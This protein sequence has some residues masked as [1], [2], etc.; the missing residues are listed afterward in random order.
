MNHHA[1]SFVLSDNAQ[2]TRLGDAGLFGSNSG[3]LHEEK[4]DFGGLGGHVKKI[5]N[6][7][8]KVT[9]VTDGNKLTLIMCGYSAGSI[10]GICNSISSGDIQV[11]SRPSLNR[12]NFPGRNSELKE[13]DFAENGSPHGAPLRTSTF[14]KYPMQQPRPDSQLT[15]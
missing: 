15:T 9:A 2:S 14:R 8:Y 12:A 6:H 10:F 5:F 4:T 3:R 13:L 7:A 11:D 1:D